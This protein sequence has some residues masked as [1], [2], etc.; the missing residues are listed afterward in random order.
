M[1]KNKN[2]NKKLKNKINKMKII[3]INQIKTMKNYKK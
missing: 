2:I 1:M 3:I